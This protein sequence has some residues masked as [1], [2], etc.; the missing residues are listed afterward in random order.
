M[1]TSDGFGMPP[2]LTSPYPC[3]KCDIDSD[4]WEKILDDTEEVTRRIAEF[5]LMRSLHRISVLLGERST[6]HICSSGEHQ[7]EVFGKNL[8]PAVYG[9]A[10]LNTLTAHHTVHTTSAIG[11]QEIHIR[12]SYNL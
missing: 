4:D 6:C 3:N 10:R 9:E 1:N 11:K 2:Q 8:D 5:L 12:C 7:N